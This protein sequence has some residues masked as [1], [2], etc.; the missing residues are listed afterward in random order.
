MVAWVEV[1]P[2]PDRSSTPAVSGR[3]GLDTSQASAMAA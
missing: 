1:I 3:S 2:I